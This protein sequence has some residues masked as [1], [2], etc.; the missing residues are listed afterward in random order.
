MCLRCRHAERTAALARLKRV[1]LR[2]S[3]VAIV[4][5]TFITAA[6]VGA[7]A[8]R[9]KANADT[10]NASSADSAASVSAPEIDSSAMKQAA[11]TQVPVAHTPAPTSAPQPAPTSTAPSAPTA[12]TTAAF[13]PTIQ[14]GES[15][16][17]PDVVAVRSDSDVVVMFDKPMLR[18]RRPDKFELF[19][20][21]TLPAIYG[22][23]AADAIG[24][25][26][27]G[28]IAAQGELLTELPAR[29]VRIP[30]NATSMIRVFPE[31]RPGQDGPLVVR[32]RARI[33]PIGN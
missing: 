25:I 16:I 10:A 24:K 4:I 1:M 13:A 7:S 19:L 26:A 18:T 27:A 21:S 14:K 28:N 22:A 5:V 15:T 3:A 11:T 31:T 33:V 2:G 20:R 8:I 17:A 30:L 29:G 12:S 32:Y 9:S 23:P 6:S